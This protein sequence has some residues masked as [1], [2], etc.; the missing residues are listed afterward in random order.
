MEENQQEVNKEAAE[1]TQPVEEVVEAEPVVQAETAS[2]DD[3]EK[4]KGMA[5]LA[6]ILFFIPML[7]EAK[8]SEF[9]M[10]H[11]NQSLIILIAGF[12]LMFINI[13]PILGQIVWLV[14]SIA[15]FIFWI[16]GIINASKGEMKELPLIGGIHILDKK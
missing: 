1:T 5:I 16:M 7:T 6:Y 10:F 15:L 11:A 4:N 9:A 2:S 14:G 12:V 3:A 8:D 13:I